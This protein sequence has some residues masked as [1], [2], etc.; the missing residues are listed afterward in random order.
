M[1]STL[2]NP[3]ALRGVEFRN[4]RRVSPMCPHLGEQRDSM[5]EPWRPVYLRWFARSGVGAVVTGV[6][7]NVPEK[8]TTTQDLGSWSYGHRNASHLI[9]DVFRSQVAA[10]LD[11]ELPYA[12][13][14]Y[15][16]APR[17]RPAVRT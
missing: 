6:T 5:P 16:R 7:A 15:P 11:V 9:I 13:Q 14:P 2:S 10:A 17:T 1:I 12:P 3:I 4:R 8:Q